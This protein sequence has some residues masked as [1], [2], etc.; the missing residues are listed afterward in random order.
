MKREHGKDNTERHSDW[1]SDP[2]L[3]LGE[4]NKDSCVRKRA[5]SKPVTAPVKVA[6]PTVETRVFPWNFILG[7]TSPH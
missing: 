3:E 6:C 7:D 1:D 2:D 4:E 5:L